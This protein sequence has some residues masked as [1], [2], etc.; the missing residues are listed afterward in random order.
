MLTLLTGNKK[1]IV[2]EQ[3]LISN[4]IWFWI[5]L[6]EILIIIA[7]IYKVYLKK[8]G[9][10]LTY[11]ETNKLKDS[12]KN[13]INMDNLMNSIH[14]SRT[15]YKELSKKCHPD[16]FINDQKQKKAEEIFQEISKNERNFEKLSILK[17]RAINELNINF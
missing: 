15:L 11:L 2:I 7:L 9:L 4:S 8:E 14:N 3:G 5:A 6:V 17:T 1:N 12:K 16:R 13:N 10:N